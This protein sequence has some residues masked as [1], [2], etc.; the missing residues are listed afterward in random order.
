[1]S[2]GDVRSGSVAGDLGPE[3]ARALLAAFTDRSGWSSAAGR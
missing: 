2:E 1:M 3:D